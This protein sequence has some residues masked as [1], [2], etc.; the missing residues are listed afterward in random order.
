MDYAEVKAKELSIY[1]QTD[2]VFTAT[3]EESDFLRRGL[4]IRQAAYVPDTF[5]LSR[6]VPGFDEREGLV[7]LAGFRHAP[8]L[9][10]AMYLLNDILPHIRKELG[11][12]PLYLVGM[13]RLSPSGSWPTSTRSS[14]AGSPSLNRT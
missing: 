13:V 2:C 4:G 1:R 6:D 10:A 5:P 3:A 9:D 11:N 12:V 8:N 14:P 7:F